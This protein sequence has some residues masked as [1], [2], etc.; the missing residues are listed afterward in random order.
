MSGYLR[1]DGT[2]DAATDDSGWRGTGDLCSMDDD[3]VVTFRGRRREVI[4]RGGANIYPAEVEQAMTAHESIA[5]IAVFGVSDER[6]GER[7]VAAVIPKTGAAAHPADL[8]AF[9]QEQLS[10]QK[11]PTE[12]FV[13][14]D[15]PRTSAVK[16]RKH[17]LRDRFSR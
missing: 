4:I 10:S 2:L 3:G 15:F 12:W 8:A 9:A 17:L 6:L 7:V 13:V 11:R 14:D 16:V 5:E 1:A